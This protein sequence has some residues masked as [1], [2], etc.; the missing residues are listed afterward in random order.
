[1]AFEDFASFIAMGGHGLYVWTSYAVAALV[2]VF[3]LTS[4]WREKRRVQ[5]SISR[6]LRRESAPQGERR[7]AAVNRESN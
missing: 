6:Q 7:I 2:I 3:N 1:M 4:P 5:A